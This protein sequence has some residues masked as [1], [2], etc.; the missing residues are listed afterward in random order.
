MA[1]A[2]ALVTRHLEMAVLGSLNL[3]CGMTIGTDGP[4]FVI[5]CQKLAVHARIV[6]LFNT[7]V[8]FPAGFCD[9]DRID[10]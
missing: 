1:T 3:V 4:S 5:S 8:A 7:N 2:A 6:S 10:R 9:V